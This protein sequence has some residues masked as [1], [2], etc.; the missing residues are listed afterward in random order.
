MKETPHG[1]SEIYSDVIIPKGTYVYTI[2][3]G[4]MGVQYRRT[5]QTDNPLETRLLVYSNLFGQM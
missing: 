4:C 3:D 1:V 5:P 2:F